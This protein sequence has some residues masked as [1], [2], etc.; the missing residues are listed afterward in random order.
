MYYKNQYLR[1]GIGKNILKN[2]F[3]I[4]GVSDYKN[5]FDLDLNLKNNKELLENLNKIIFLNFEKKE[6]YL[7][8][9]K[10]L[11]EKKKIN[12]SYK[13]YKYFRGLPIYNQRT[14]T[15]SRTSRK[16]IL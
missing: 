14:K 2:I 6:V 1:Y 8:N 4:N 7:K 13:G 15:N 10:L 11:L 12:G 5:K 16:K 3:N 9:K